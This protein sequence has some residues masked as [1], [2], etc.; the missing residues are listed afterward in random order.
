MDFLE[1]ARLNCASV[2]HFNSGGQLCWLSLGSLTC[3]GVAWL[4]VVLPQSHSMHSSSSVL[5]QVYHTDWQASLRGSQ[6]ARHDFYCK[7][8]GHDLY[9]KLARH[10]FYCILLGDARHREFNRNQRGKIQGKVD[11]T[12]WWKKDKKSQRKGSGTQEGQR[13]G[14]VL[15]INWP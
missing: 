6:L 9:C 14:N 3:L 10:Y 13:I 7:L 8:A 12:S 11:S 4:W 15:V 1:E 5:A 2:V